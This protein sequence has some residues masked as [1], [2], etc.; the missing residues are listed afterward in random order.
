M[1]TA[2]SQMPGSAAAGSTY[3]IS[4][5]LL[6]KQ[7]KYMKTT[8]MKTNRGHFFRACYSKGVGHHLHL[9]ESQWQPEEQESFMVRKREGFRY[10][11]IEGCWPGKAEGGLTR[12]GHLIGLVW[13]KI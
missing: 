8:Q 12:I 3:H 11:L 5:E 6:V 10:T 1:D 4:M 13:R 2:P 7:W 9:A